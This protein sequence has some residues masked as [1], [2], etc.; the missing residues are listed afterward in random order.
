M[1]Y[2]YVTV[3]GYCPTISKDHEIEIKYVNPP[4]TIGYKVTSIYCSIEEDCPN[5]NNCPIYENF[6]YRTT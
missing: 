5:S 6:V 2:K 1:N 3:S 4:G